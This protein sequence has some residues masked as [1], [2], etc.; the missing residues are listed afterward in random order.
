M[1]IKLIISVFAFFYSLTTTA[2][3]RF[4]FGISNTNFSLN[5]IGNQIAFRPTYINPA[6]NFNVKFK[7][8]KKLNFNLRAELSFQRIKFKN[9]I[10]NAL[11]EYEENIIG[12]GV[13]YLFFQRKDKLQFYGL[14]LDF[15]LANKQINILYGVQQNNGYSTNNI[16]FP[17]IFEDRSDVVNLHIT[18]NN[19]VYSP[20]VGLGLIS[21]NHLKRF[22]IIDYYFKLDYYLKLPATATGVSTKND[23]IVFSTT[24]KNIFYKLGITCYFGAMKHLHTF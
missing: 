17:L 5:K 14:L 18:S 23:E 1:K 4:G 19:Q 8:A 24:P 11:L 12:T 7:V 21:E 3:I 20:V 10:N 2:Q 9:E 13:Q 15:A 6:I 22:F 16:Q